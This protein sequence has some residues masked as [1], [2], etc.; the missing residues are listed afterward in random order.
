MFSALHS[1]TTRSLSMASTSSSSLG[2][3]ST[4]EDIRSKARQT[5]DSASEAAGDARQQVEEVA[6]NV[7]EVIDR[8]VKD[9]PV[10]TL[11]VAAAVGFVI[12]ALWMS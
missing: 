8:S 12:G 4:A 2:S 7:K 1:D 11:L 10:T 6:G 5:L 3:S 9:Q